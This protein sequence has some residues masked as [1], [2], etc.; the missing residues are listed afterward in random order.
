M[1]SSKPMVTRWASLNVV[2]H[3]T[4]SRLHECEKWTGK[5]TG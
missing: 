3:K 4:K 5:G 1:K 2:V